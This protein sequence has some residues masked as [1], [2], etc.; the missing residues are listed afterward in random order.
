[1]AEQ[2]NNEQINESSS[3]GKSVALTGERGGILGVKSG[4]TQIYDAEGTCVP[5]TVIDLQQPNVVT[6]IRNEQKN[7]YTAVQVGYHPRKAQ[8][9]SKA[10]KGHFKKSGNPGYRVVTEFRV[11][12]TD[13]I[14]EGAT[15]SIDF[16]KVGDKVDVTATSKGKGFQGVMKKFHFAGGFKSHGAS[17][18]HRAPGSIG[19]RADPGRVFPGKKMPGQMGNKRVTVQ[20]LEV[21]GIDKENNLIMVRGAIPGPKQGVVRVHKAVKVAR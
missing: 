15:L 5:V 9:C 6:M 11:P 19:N 1:M 13:G 4:M 8:N 17:V 14:S 21:M 3:Q 2:A 16:I 18:S 10:D 7:G 20:N 12:S